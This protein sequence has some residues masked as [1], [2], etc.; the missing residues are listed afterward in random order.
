MGRV[1]ED[2]NR[3]SVWL[4]VELAHLETLEDEG[5][6]PQGT[7]QAVR[8]KARIRTTRIEELETTLQHDVIAFLTSIGEELSNE[9]QWLHYGM[10]SSDLVD[11]SQAILL[12]QALDRIELAWK[13]LGDVLRE[14]AL[15]HR[16]L[17]MVG[18]THGVHAEP[19]TFGFKVLGW[20]AEASRDAGRLRRARQEIGHGKLSGAVG[21]AAH[22][23]P[24][25][26]AGVMRRLGLAPEPAATQVVPRDRHAVFLQ[27]LALVGTSMERWATEIR[28]LQKTEVRELEEPFGKGQKG[29]SAMPHKR[30]PVVCERIAGLARVVRASAAAS[31]ENIALWHERDISHSSAERVILADACIAIDYMIERITFVLDGLV[32]RPE[33]MLRN[34][35]ATGGLIYSQRV[36]LALT[37]AWRDRERA[38]R[39]V[40]TRAMDVWDKGGTLRDRLLSDPEVMGVLGRDAIDSL[41]RPDAFMRNLDEVFDRTLGIPWGE[42]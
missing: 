22:L 33:A 31:M 15:R 11:T 10:T 25:V 27:T 32:V 5:I 6:A 19:I 29:S 30:N 37:E 18:R 20:Y 3:Y 14:L 28:H 8:D 4:D 39:F 16:G 42:A 21:T 9:K 40:Q 41:F 34:L 17:P 26:E 13:R 23:A 24:S 7:A 35:E 36:L 2:E 38:Y 12:L 1:F